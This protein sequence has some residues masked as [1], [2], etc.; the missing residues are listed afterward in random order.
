[1][2]YKDEAYRFFEFARRGLH[3]DGYMMHKYQADGALGSSWHSYVHDG[4]IT[5]PIQEDETALVLFVFA[6]FYQMNPDHKLLKEFYKDMVMPMANFMAS[7]IDR[8]TGLPRSSYDLWEQTFTT[9]TY[10]TA[11]TYAALLA[12]SDLAAAASDQVNAIK[13]RLAANDI[14]I[15]ARKYLYND[16]KKVFYRGLNI[17]NGR[18]VLDDVVDC[19]SVFGA[20]TFGLFASD[21]K[22]I[23]SSVETIKQLF[24][25]NSGAPGLPRYEND[26]YRRVSPG[27]TGNY[28]FVTSFWLAQ[29]YIDSDED[30]KALDILDWAKSKALSTGVMSEQFDPITNSIISPAPLTWTHAE[31]ISTLLDMIAKD[32]K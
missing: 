8:I 13:W 1:M 2:G 19:S 12:A 28:W 31:Y 26:E 10:T 21:S 22:E 20:Y 5:P 16:T 6:Q 11:V 25:I 3:P 4:V 23:K 29:Y 32:K 15:A 17:R 18:V 30:K 7:F 9:S 24:G 27:I 14:Q